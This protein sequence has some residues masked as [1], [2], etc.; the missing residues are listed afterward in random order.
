M[1]LDESH[2]PAGQTN[3]DPEGRNRK[4]NLHVQ[5]VPGSRHHSRIPDV[6]YF[7]PVVV[8]HLLRG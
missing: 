6:Y 1:I 8:M 2:F 7:V 3:V 5:F 4:T